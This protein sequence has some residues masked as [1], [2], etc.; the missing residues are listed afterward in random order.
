M[1]TFYRLQGEG[2]P[3]IATYYI[4]YQKGHDQKEI[5]Q[6]TWNDINILI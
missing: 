6:K 5:G 1:P 4:E 2:S 3:K